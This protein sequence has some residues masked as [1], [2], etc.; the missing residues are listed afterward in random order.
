MNGIFFR[1]FHYVTLIKGY[2]MTDGICVNSRCDIYFPSLR[3]LCA[4]SWSWL[5]ALRIFWQRK[6]V[7]HLHLALFNAILIYKRHH[8]LSSSI[9]LVT[10]RFTYIFH[11][12]V[13]SIHYEYRSKN[14]DDHVHLC[15]FDLLSLFISYFPKQLYTLDIPCMCMPIIRLMR[16]RIS[17][18]NGIM[19][20]QAERYYHFCVVVTGV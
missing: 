1:K 2:N 13:Q 3:V 10:T 9:A 12:T 17:H 5:I 19:M 6:G 7:I 20:T 16:I 15:R 18:E 4:P 8:F 14:L 11:W